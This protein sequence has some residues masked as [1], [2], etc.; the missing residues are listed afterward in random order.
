MLTRPPLSA[1]SAQPESWLGVLRR[2]RSNLQHADGLN[3]VVL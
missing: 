3:F 1:V 2:G